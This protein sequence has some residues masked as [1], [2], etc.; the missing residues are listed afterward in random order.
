[1]S[2]ILII[3]SSLRIG[4]NSELLARE[5]EKGAKESGNNV[6]FLSLKG[7]NI[8]YCVGCLTC[9]KTKKCILEDDM[10]LLLPLLEE[11]EIICFASP[12]YYYGMSGILKTFLDRTNPLYDG[13]YHFKDLY[14]IATCADSDP[15]CID[16]FVDSINGWSE[17]YPRSSVKGVIRGVSLENSNDAAKASSLLQEAYEMGRSIH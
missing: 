17:C 13:D 5:F 6:A 15:S 11:A 3:S 16:R 12:I 10:K 14:L 9:Q 1:M 7:K 2:K 4:S 8:K